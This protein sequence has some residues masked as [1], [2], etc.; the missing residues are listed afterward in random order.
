[1]LKAKRSRRLIVRI[2]GQ[3]KKKERRKKVSE[4]K[5]H[6]YDHQLYHCMIH[7]QV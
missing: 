7:I 1:M 5:E 3:K 2:S 6:R 4:S